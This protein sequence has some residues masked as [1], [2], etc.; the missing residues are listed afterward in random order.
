MNRMSFRTLLP[1]AP[2]LVSALIGCSHEHAAPA[3]ASPPPPAPEAASVTHTTSQTVSKPQEGVNVSDE[4]Q[5]ACQIDV[6]NVETSPKFDFNK[7]ELRS[8][9]RAVLEAVAK[10]VTTG[11]L[12][13]RSQP[14]S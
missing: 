13:G 4:I 14:G 9:E 11:P 7:S 6:N 8:D 5:K 1:L 10:C 12:Q 2:L 3:A